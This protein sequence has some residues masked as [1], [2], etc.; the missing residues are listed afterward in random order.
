M[1]KLKLIL[2]ASI[3]TPQNRGFNTIFQVR[4]FFFSYYNRLLK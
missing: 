4:K 2:I 1:K 3:I